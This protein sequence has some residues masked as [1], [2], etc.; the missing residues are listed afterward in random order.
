M[1]KTSIAVVIIS[2]GPG[3]L[4]TWVRPIVDN[5]NKIN[6]SS[7]INDRLNFTINLVLVPCPNATGREYEVAKSWKKFALVTKARTFW[8]LLIRPYQFAK[9]LSLIHI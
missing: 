6:D 7:K 9:W 8:K 3:E 1:Q 5:L 2:N 4:S